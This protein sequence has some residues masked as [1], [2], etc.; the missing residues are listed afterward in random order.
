MSSKRL[1]DPR[2]HTI[3]RGA[4]H[5]ATKFGVPLNV[6]ILLAVG[7]ALPGFW[8]VNVGFMWALPFWGSFFPLLF[9]LRLISRKDPYTLLQMMHRARLRATQRNQRFW[10]AVTYSPFTY[11]SHK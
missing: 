5:P 8:L 4:T 1:N 3:A 2:R 7:C 10:G 9:V 11:G 6:F